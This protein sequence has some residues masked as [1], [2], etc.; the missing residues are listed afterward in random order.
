MFY[1]V[2]NVVIYGVYVFK[3]GVVLFVYQS[4]NMFWLVVGDLKEWLL[5]VMM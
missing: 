4:M 2:Y 3:N 5:Y 1:R